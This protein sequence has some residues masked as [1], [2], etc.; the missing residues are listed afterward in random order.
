[1]SFSELSNRLNKELTKEDRSING[2]FF[3][4]K[5]ARNKLFERLAALD[6]SPKTILEPSCGS[7]EFID[8]C[9]SN[10]PKAL[11]TGIE[12]HPIIFKNLLESEL[13]LN[14]TKKLRLINTDF[15]KYGDSKYD[16]IIGNPPYFVTKDKNPACMNGRGNI[17]VQFIYKCLTENLKPD[18]ILAFVLPT[19]FY[20]CSYYSQCRDYISKNT[21]LL[22][23]DNIDASYYETAQDT[24]IMIIKNTKPTNKDYIFIRNNNVYITPF[25]E[26]LNQIVIDTKTISELGFRVKT[27]EVVWNQHKEKL[28]D[29][30]GTQACKTAQ[31]TQ[32]CKTAKTAQSTPIIYPQN[33]VDSKLVL[34]NLKPD[35][36]NEKKQYIN[37]EYISTPT[38]GPAILISRGF[39]NKYNFIYT[40]IEDSSFSFYGENHI[41]VVYPLDK[42]IDNYE[43]F[44]KIKRSLKDTKTNDF[45]KLFVGNGALSKTELENV[46]P[47]F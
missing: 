4:P 9:L 35:K 41:N 38:T 1:M 45:I 29:K 33:I 24:M 6:I 15:L 39:G 28:I 13:Y 11:V 5:M 37:D 3:T 40:T 26:R 30:Q 23:V 27:G 10:Y 25:Y 21:T 42:S 47:I 22:Y 7:G 43:A 2:I 20:N 16:L 19:S 44:D 14:N 31:S 34:N 46:L 18:C 32:A 17:F 12:K 8:D 36:K